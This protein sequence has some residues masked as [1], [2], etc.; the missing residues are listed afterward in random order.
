VFPDKSPDDISRSK[1]TFFKDSKDAMVSMDM[2]YATDLEEVFVPL[3]FPVPGQFF[4]KR[5]FKAEIQLSDGV[6][7]AYM[8][9][10]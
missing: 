4:S 5:I 2:T 1:K 7:V 10:A 3:V 6:N 8:T 9:S